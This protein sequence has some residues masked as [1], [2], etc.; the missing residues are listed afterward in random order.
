MKFVNIIHCIVVKWPITNNYPCRSIYFTFRAKLPFTKIFYVIIL[1]ENTHSLVLIRRTDN[2]IWNKKLVICVSKIVFLFMIVGIPSKKI[3]ALDSL[4][5]ASLFPK[6]C[7]FF[8]IGS[9]LQIV[10][11]LVLIHCFSSFDNIPRGMNY[12]QEG[13]KI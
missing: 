6:R 11:I 3:K 2:P 4:R 5:N 9:G 1:R 12:P 10:L 7:S 8:L 13:C